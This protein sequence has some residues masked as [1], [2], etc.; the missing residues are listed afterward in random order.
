MQDPQLVAMAL[1]YRAQ[2]YCMKMA[3][4]QRKDEHRIAY[5]DAA[6]LIREARER[7]GQP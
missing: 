1:L 5:N 3:D 6:K 2:M 4:H 7:I